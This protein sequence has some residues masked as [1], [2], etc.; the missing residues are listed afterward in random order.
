MGMV[1]MKKLAV[2][3]LI[4]TVV[5][6]GC[7]STSSK[8]FFEPRFKEFCYNSGGR[9]IDFYGQSDNYPYYANCY[10]EIEYV[11][12]DQRVCKMVIKEDLVVRWKDF[13]GFAK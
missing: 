12:M 5:V 2:I 6:M 7:L 1:K 4:G 11:P 8:Y 9:L 10:F 3:L 13:C